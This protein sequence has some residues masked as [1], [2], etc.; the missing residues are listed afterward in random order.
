MNKRNAPII[1]SIIVVI[2]MLL[3]LLLPVGIRATYV[4]PII[5]IAAVAC[6]FWLVMASRQTVSN[7]TTKSDTQK[8]LEAHRGMYSADAWREAKFHEAELLRNT[9][10]FNDNLEELLKKY[11]GQFVAIQDGKMTI[12]P[13]QDELMKKMDEKPG[14]IIFP[15]RRF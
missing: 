2:L 3:S 1:T 14:G 6:A 11:P 13:D 15:I 10:V 12:G 7:E 4:T 9:K 8:V 5:G